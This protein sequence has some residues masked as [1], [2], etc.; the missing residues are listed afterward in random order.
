MVICEEGGTPRPGAGGSRHP[1]AS[2]PIEWQKI[3]PEKETPSG[4]DGRSSE[5]QYSGRSWGNIS[6]IRLSI[7]DVGTVYNS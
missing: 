2:K 5:V 6:R 7:L 1:F 4:Y 3:S